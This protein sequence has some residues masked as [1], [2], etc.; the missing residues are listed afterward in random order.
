MTWFN[1][2]STLVLY[3]INVRIM[4][5]FGSVDRQG[6]PI[7]PLLGQNIQLNYLSW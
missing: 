2:H 1:S 7:N 6:N 3:C 4:Y 5:E